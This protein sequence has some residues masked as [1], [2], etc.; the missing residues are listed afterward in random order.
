MIWLILGLLVFLG[1]HSVRI[2]AD[3]WR[4][5]MIARIGLNHWKGL[6]S[7]ASLAGFVL[8]V[9]GYGE[10]RRLGLPLYDPPPFTRHIA[11]LLMLPSM[12]L[13][14]ATYVSRNHFK[15]RFGHPMLLAVKLWALAHL[16]SNGRAAEVILFGAFLAWAVADFIAARRRDRAAGTVYPPGEGVRTVIV[17]IAG[18]ALWVVFA[19]VLHQWLIGVAPFMRS[20]AV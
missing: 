4:T 13:L 1:V 17:L 18:T 10:A 11:A 15:A 8:L 12:V 20:P 6:Y 9:I 14:V 7:L 3:P 19:A 5:R 2:V 16:L